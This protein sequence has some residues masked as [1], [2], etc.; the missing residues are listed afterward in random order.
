MMRKGTESLRTQIVSLKTGK[1]QHRRTKR[2]AFIV[3]GLAMLCGSHNNKSR[4]KK[5]NEK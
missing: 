4:S 2:F 1:G 5:G 3:K